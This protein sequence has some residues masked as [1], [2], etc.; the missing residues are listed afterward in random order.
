MS[1]HDSSS[2]RPR[3]EGFC[4]LIGCEAMPSLFKIGRTSRNPY[5][6]IAEISA[7]TGIPV[8]FNLICAIFVIDCYFIESHLHQ[9]FEGRRINQAREFFQFNDVSDAR[10]N[11]VSA[12]S[13][14]AHMIDIMGFTNVQ[15]GAG[16]A[17]L[18]REILDLER[19]NALLESSLVKLQNEKN[20]LKSTIT[21]L[22]NSLHVLAHDTQVNYEQRISGEKSKHD[23]YIHSLE[24]QL[25]LFRNLCRDN[26]Y[27]LALQIHERWSK[28]RQG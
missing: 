2:E 14:N 22:Q 12:I 26:P 20:N 1:G 28:N 9:K 4:Y 23:K 17:T 10:N 3:Q 6:R 7:A 27:D 8:K 15:H 18:K 19:K 25:E 13:E 21:H 5:E 24:Q 11:F 16:V